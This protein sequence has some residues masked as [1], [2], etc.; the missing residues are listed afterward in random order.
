MRFFKFYF[1]VLLL[2]FIS[3]AAGKETRNNYAGFDKKV[4]PKG[5][6]KLQ[7]HQLRPIDY[8]HK[9]P[10]IKGILVN[11]Y[12]GTGKTLLGIGIAESYPGKPVIILAPKFLESQWKAEIEKF[13]A[14]EP[15]RYEFVAYDN[16]PNQLKGRDLKDHIILA[17]EAHN[18]IKY[19]ESLDQEKNEQYAEVY[20]KIRKGFKVIALTG[21]PVFN[22]ESNIATLLNLVSG[23][24]LLPF[25]KERFRNE[26]TKVLPERKYFRGYLTESNFVTQIALPF[27]SF[28]FFSGLGSVLF[29]DN[30]A[31]AL[32]LGSGV[33]F[34]SAVF[35]PVIINATLD[36]NNFKLRV[37]DVDK[38]ADL[39]EKYVSFFRFDE[40]TFKDFPK[41]DYEVKE[42]SYNRYQYSFFLKLAEG[43]LPDA[44]LKR[45]LQNEQNKKS[46]EYIK[47]NSSLIH[48]NL[49]NMVGSGRDIGNFAFKDSAG[50]L[51]EP[52]KFEA[53]LDDIITRNVQTLVYS[54]YYETGILA[55]EKFLKR[56]KFKKPYAIIHPKLTN[57]EISEIVNKYNNQKISLVLLHPSVTEGISFKRTELIEFLEPLE[58][59]TTEEQVIGRGRR[60]LSHQDLP[61][62]RQVVHVNVW[63]STNSS[64]E[65]GDIKRANWYD[66]Y[67]ELNY[68]SRWGIGIKQIMKNSDR[69]LFN[70]EEATLLK[71]EAL[72]KNLKEMQHVLTRRSIESNYR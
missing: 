22:D 64:W 45:L 51:V 66:R 57:Q 63:K 36:L 62:E 60:F 11:H 55:F 52:P 44:Q 21:T 46:N 15:N 24:D 68:L 18:L 42:I 49:F 10:D 43:D 27:S 20:V 17:D 54:N 14:A 41:L 47:I 1:L 19:M 37:L 26:Y 2:F 69:K 5:N 50:H 38:M 30:V 7:E 35:T 3:C 61:I 67:N 32:L 71:A 65:I 39:L 9:N 12:M 16:A 8:L 70:P 56:K 48:E 34:L 25:N 59:K 40:S 53:V 28:A 6:V 31:L 4:F 23:K 33:G 72:E 29:P 58:N 13:G